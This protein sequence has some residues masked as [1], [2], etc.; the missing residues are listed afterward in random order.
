MR[1]TVAALGLVLGVL[2]SGCK[3][4]AAKVAPPASPAERDDAG[5]VALEVPR[6]DDPAEVLPPPPPVRTAPRGLPPTPSPDHNQTTPAKVELGQLLFFEPALSA[7][8]Q[9]ACASCHRPEHG[10]SAPEPR[11]TVVG[12]QLNL[13]H[14]LSLW[15]AAYQREWAWDGSMPT[16]EAHILSHWKGQLAA[17]PDEVARTLSAARGYAG[18][19]QRAFRGPPTRERITEAL[20]AFVRTRRSGDAPWDQHEAGVSGAVDADAIAGA[21]VFAERAGCATCHMPPLYTDRGYHDRGLE[22]HAADPGRARATADAR[23]QGAF[24]TPTLRGVV[25][26]APY[27]HDGSAA[28]LEAAVDHELGRSQVTLTSGERRQLLAFIR[29]LSS[30]PLRPFERPELPELPAAPE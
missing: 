8:R 30:A 3:D 29:A 1:G 11:S 21:R 22:P 13:R 5:P 24:R 14:T 10:W 25:H 7:G 12:G 27:F 28:T 2:C 17:V 19:F 20:A 23:D 9:R 6:I 15:N 26:T 16:L 18:R 4:E